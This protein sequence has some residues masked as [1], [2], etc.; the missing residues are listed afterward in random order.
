MKD[1]IHI[2]FSATCLDK[3]QPEGSCEGHRIGDTVLPRAAALR[4]SAEKNIL[5]FRQE[6]TISLEVV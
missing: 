3:P 6:I 1:S 2:L 4:I 5:A